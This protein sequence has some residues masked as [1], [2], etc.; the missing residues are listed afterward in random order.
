MAIVPILPSNS[1]LAVITVTAVT[2]GTM[3]VAVAVVPLGDL[4][5]PGP[6]DVAVRPLR[7]RQL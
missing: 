2:A 6:A 3:T 5:L 4:S 1:V 7:H